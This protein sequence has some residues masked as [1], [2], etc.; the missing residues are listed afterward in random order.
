M[1]WFRRNIVNTSGIGVLIL[2][3]PGVLRFRDIINNFRDFVPPLPSL[4]Q[5]LRAG[6]L[7]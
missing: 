6:D 1:G 3:V 4:D 5:R 7:Q 2:S